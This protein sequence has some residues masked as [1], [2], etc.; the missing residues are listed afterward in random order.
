LIIPVKKFGSMLISR[1][2]GKEAASIMLSSFKPVSDEERIELD[3]TDVAVIA[4]SWLHEVVV[5]LRQ[6]YGDRVDCLENDNLSLIESLK[7]I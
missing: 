1:P 4:P 3:F 2:A 5:T 6:A 7:F